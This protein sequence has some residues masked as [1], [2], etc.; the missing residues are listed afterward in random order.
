[1]SLAVGL[2]LG[3]NSRNIKRR[4]WISMINVLPQRKRTRT[5]ARPGQKQSQWQTKK[6]IHRQ[7]CSC[8]LPCRRPWCLTFS[9]NNNVAEAD[10]LRLKIISIMHI[11]KEQVCDIMLRF[12]NVTSFRP[13]R[14]STWTLSC[15]IITRKG[16]RVNPTY[17]VK[18]NS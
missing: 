9:C 8:K 4:F 17:S 5:I 11:T 12:P 15:A 6:Q 18:H 10:A 14:H 16:V 1:M 2:S 13:P 7:T 3:S